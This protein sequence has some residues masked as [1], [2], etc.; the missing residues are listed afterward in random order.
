MNDSCF[1]ALARVCVPIQLHLGA[2][3]ATGLFPVSVALSLVLAAK[4]S[5]AG[6][7]KDKK[8][9]GQ[10]IVEPGEEF[11]E[12][13]VLK[14]QTASV[15]SKWCECSFTITLRCENNNL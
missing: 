5:Y 11:T 2:S 1:L 14:N 9:N 7:L 10:E 8:G 12:T 15:V 4:S 3:P 13:A 6:A